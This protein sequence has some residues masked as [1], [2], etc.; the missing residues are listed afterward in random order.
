[1]NHWC[2]NL[3]TSDTFMPNTEVKLQARLRT[4][5]LYCLMAGKWKGKEAVR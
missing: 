1:M 4:T 5:H 2:R 3:S